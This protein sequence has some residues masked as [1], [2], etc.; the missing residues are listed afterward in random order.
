MAVSKAKT[1]VKKY[2]NIYVSKLRPNSINSEKI[3]SRKLS[4]P[5]TSKQ[6]VT[7]L[8]KELK[9]TFSSNGRI[10]LYLLYKASTEP[11]PHYY[12]LSISK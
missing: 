12:T 4:T 6:I 1:T 10:G 8:N 5:L 2:S 11:T 7:M 3:L 9:C